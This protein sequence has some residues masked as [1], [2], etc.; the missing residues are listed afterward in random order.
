MIEVNA[1][2]HD[3]KLK[4]YIYQQQYEVHGLHFWKWFIII[5]E[6]QKPIIVSRVQVDGAALGF[7]EDRAIRHNVSSN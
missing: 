6:Y 1:W 3:F 2:Q 4:K 5:D 7:G